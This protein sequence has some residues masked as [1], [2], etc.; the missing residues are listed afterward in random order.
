[1]CNQIWK[2]R[3][4]P[5]EWKKSVFLTL[6]K[7]GDASECKNHRTIALIPHASKIL[8]HIINERLKPHLDRE[9]PAEQAGFRK[10]RG[11]RDQIANLRHI[12]EK[13]HE[14][15]KNIYLCFIDYAKAFDCVRHSSLEI[16]LQEMGIPSHLIELIHNLYEGQAACVRTEKGNSDWFSLGQGV[17]QGCILSPSLFN[18]YAEFIMRRAMDGWSGGLSI[19]GRKVNNLRYAD[20]T[21]LITTSMTEM[22]EL[23][24]DHFKTQPAVDLP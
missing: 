15:Q 23:L 14:F 11:T 21:T 4:W 5:E 19:G 16:A 22:A 3:T 8:L 2:T 20:D 7:K 6:P 24:R 17:R 1:M 9:L 13:S 10:G 12:I 18:L